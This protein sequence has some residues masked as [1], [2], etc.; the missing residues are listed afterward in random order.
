MVVPSLAGFGLITFCVT[1]DFAQRVSG[2]NYFFFSVF[3]ASGSFSEPKTSAYASFW[4]GVRYDS[5]ARR[6]SLSPGV[7]ALNSFLRISSSLA[8][9]VLSIRVMMMSFDFY[10]ASGVVGAVV[11]ADASGDA[12]GAIAGVSGVTQ[13]CKSA[14]SSFNCSFVIGL[15]FM[16]DDL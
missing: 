6:K 12:A 11:G 13:L 8:C 16:I 1:L 4:A 2:D 3:G 15:L 5:R 9:D 14:M 7:S 10:W